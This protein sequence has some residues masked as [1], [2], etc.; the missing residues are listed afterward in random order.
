MDKLQKI[1]DA[2]D[3]QI[4]YWRPVEDVNDYTEFMFQNGLTYFEKVIIKTLFDDGSG[5]V[6][7][8]Y[9]YPEADENGGVVAVWDMSSYARSHNMKITHW[10]PKPKSPISTMLV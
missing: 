2:H 3:A 7:I 5:G 1:L 6:D 10:M 8:S 9:L 4:V